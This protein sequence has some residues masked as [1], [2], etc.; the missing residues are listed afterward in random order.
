MH[1]WL[2]FVHVAGVLA[3]AMAHGVSAYV[4][5]RLVKERD[6]A[7][8][9]QLL[10]LSAS[11]VGFMWNAIGVLVLAGVAAGFTGGFWGQGWIWAAIVVLVAVMAAM[12]VLGTTWATRL[13]TISAAMIEGT[14]AVSS[15]QF[16][17]VLRSK[18]P[19]ALAGIGFA[20]LLLLAWLM[21]FKPSLGLGGVAT[22]EPVDGAAA[23]VCAFDDRRFVPDRLSATPETPFALAFV[24]DDDGV[25]HNVAIYADETAQDP[26]FVGDIVE[27]PT[28]TT[29]EVSALDAGSYF[30]RCDVHPVMDGTLEVA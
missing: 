28:T 10:E 19:H 6:P 5:L 29:Y 24:N 1:P 15:E 8:V 11:S 20:G 21:I 27:G 7:R 2:V 17:E 16:E 14:E 23:T 26:L 30:F 22:C 4:T 13:R 12:Y 9:S 3:F 25:G 18:R